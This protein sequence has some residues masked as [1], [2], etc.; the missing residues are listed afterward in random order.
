[1]SILF[2]SLILAAPVEVVQEM[3]LQPLLPEVHPK[4]FLQAVG[5]LDFPCPIVQRIV[6]RG[7]DLTRESI[8]RRELTFA[9]GDTLS[10]EVIEET[11]AAIMSIGAFSRVDVVARDAGEGK[12]DAVINVEEI[13]FPLPYP[14]V[15][16]DG[17]TGFYLGAGALY[18][19]LFGHGIHIDA[20]G[21]VGFRFSTPRWKAHSCLYV[22]MTHNRWHGEKPAYDYS[23]LWR[24]DAEIYLR[25]HRASY[26]QDVR[27]CRF[28]TFSLE[29]GWLQSR[30]FG[31]ESDT[32]QYT[33]AAD[34]TD[35]SLFIQPTVRLDL[36]DNDYDTRKGLF[37]EGKFLYNPGLT[38]DFLTQ[39][40]CS[41]S[42]A[43]YLP[44]NEHNWLA[45]NLY[46]YQQIDS[47]PT[48]RTIYVGEARKVRGWAD[49]TQV[50]QCLTV[51]SLEWRNRFIDLEFA[52]L[53]LLGEFKMWWGANVFADIG[54]IH[55]P[56]LPPLYLADLTGDRKD[57]LLP[58]V[59]FG[60]A[61]G[62]GKLVG[63]LEVAWGVGSGLNG[64]NFVLTFPAYFG[65][66]F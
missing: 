21:E 8:I 35:R 11:R 45:V 14:T 33:F 48:Y 66:R 63:K 30:A 19:N 24:K 22:P 62:T 6:I 46:T 26:R 40:A 23:Y 27:A 17:S 16:I 36:R 13:R 37:M 44:L 60:I 41:L 3:P 9:P 53:P 50:G 47:I 10:H 38:D 32:H 65:W 7:N 1:M 20:G 25:E 55:E 34:T 52:D 5:P 51:L 59:G 29:G 56:G 49:T 4:D 58:G 12:T 28:L 61:A 42:V 15:G 64:S 43:G 31:L 57:G 54:A 18:P 39:R 2:L